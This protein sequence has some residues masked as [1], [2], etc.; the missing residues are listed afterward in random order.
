M[1]AQNKKASAQATASALESKVKREESSQFLKEAVALFLEAA[2]VHATPAL[3]LK[4]L[5]DN[6]DRS[7]KNVLTHKKDEVGFTE[8]AKTLNAK[9]PALV[10]AARGAED[11]LVALLSARLDDWE[12]K[13]LAAPSVDAKDSARFDRLEAALAAL[14][15][16]SAAPLSAEAGRKRSREDCEEEEME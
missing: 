7:N 10:A 11:G 13:F 5:Y 2:A 3:D 16:A 1:V 8:N 4:R 14:A 15:A 9:L 6:V 12:Y